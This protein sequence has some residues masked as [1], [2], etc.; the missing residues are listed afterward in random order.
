MKSGDLDGGGGGG[1]G[2]LALARNNGTYSAMEPP[3]EDVDIIEK[4]P[5]GRYDRVIRKISLLLSSCS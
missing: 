3:D 5:T 1:A 2:G 4:D